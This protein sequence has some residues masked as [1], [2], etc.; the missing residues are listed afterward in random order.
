MAAQR[1]GREVANGVQR[2]FAAPRAMARPLSDLQFQAIRRPFAP[3]TTV[4]ASG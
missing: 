2:I 4:D 1:Q 3:S